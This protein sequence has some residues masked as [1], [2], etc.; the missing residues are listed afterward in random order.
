MKTDKRIQNHMNHIY[1]KL[2]VILICLMLLIP[3]A[4]TAIQMGVFAKDPVVDI[5]VKA[6]DSNAPVLRIATD[7]DFCPNSYINE[8]G[9]LSGLYIEIVTEAANRLGMKPEFYRRVAGVSQYADG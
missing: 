7:Y 1:T 2:F 8:K 6:T 5:P 9:D 4:Y 3:A